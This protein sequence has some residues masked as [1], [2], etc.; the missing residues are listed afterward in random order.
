MQARH[1]ERLREGDWRR[2]QAAKSAVHYLDLAR[3]SA[4]ATW[5]S[6]LSL[7]KDHHQVERILRSAWRQTVREVAEWFPPSWRAAISWCGE[8]PELPI[9]DHSMHNLPVPSW[10]EPDDIT[11]DAARWST[12][13][14]AE[15]NAGA[16][17]LRRWRALC[18]SLSGAEAKALDVLAS[19]LFACL[20]TPECGTPDFPYRPPRDMLQAI[21]L[22]IF[23][24]QAGSPVAAFAY[25]SLVLLDFERFRGGLIE[26]MLFAEPDERTAA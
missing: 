16:V 21:C 20:E 17:W 22:R 5:A 9:R 10:A 23:R 8:L 25:L 3:N 11:A 1:G 12:T 26:R 15:A 4:L 13:A 24:R 6:P 18:P 2:L 7:N 14:Q 19:Q